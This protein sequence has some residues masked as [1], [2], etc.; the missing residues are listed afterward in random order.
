MSR[1]NAS[2]EMHKN[3]DPRV[4]RIPTSAAP[5]VAK[6][7]PKISPNFVASSSTPFL[8]EMM[9]NR[10]FDKDLNEIIN[11]ARRKIDYDEESESE[12]S[13]SQ[14]TPTQPKSMGGLDGTDSPKPPMRIPARAGMSPGPYGRPVSSKGLGTSP[15]PSYATPVINTTAANQSRPSSRLITTPTLLDHP[16]HHHQAPDVDVEMLEGPSIIDLSPNTVA[17]NKPPSLVSDD[18]EY[19]DG[20]DAERESS[21]EED[22]D[23]DVAEID[24][25]DDAVDKVVPLRNHGSSGSEAMRL[26]KEDKHVTFVSPVKEKERR[27]RRT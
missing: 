10:G 6:P 19:D 2:L 27:S 5:P 4:P 18:G 21:S 1:I 7:A 22:E 9:R 26:R 20:T 8:S 24:I 13:E 11:D 25:E 16:M 17:S 15:R 14:P 3:G 12:D 23:S